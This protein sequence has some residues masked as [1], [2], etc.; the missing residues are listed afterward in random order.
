MKLKVLIPVLVLVLALGVGA[1][2]YFSSRG[3]GGEEEAQS[4]LIPMAENIVLVGGG[5]V[6]PA[7]QNMINLKY[8]YQA[9]STDGI[10][11]IGLLAN[12]PGNE[13]DMFVDLFADAEATD[14]LFL[15]GLLPPGTGIQRIALNR[16]LPVGT[17]TVYVAFNQ[18]DTDEDG[19][20]AIVGQAVVTVE[21]IVT[22]E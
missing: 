11:F 3:N 14:R 1:G 22:E 7:P 12:D 17:N 20:Q 6:Q 15:S 2:V 4:G 5:D 18:V 19:E 21:F 10:N 9:F 13:Y 16:A 8:N